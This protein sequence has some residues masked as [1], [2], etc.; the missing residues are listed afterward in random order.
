MLR[1]LLCPCCAARGR[2]PPNPRRDVFW[3]LRSCFFVTAAVHV[4]QPLRDLQLIALGKQRMGTMIIVSTIA[5]ALINPIVGD[6]FQPQSKSGGKPGRCRST[7]ES[8]KLFYR[9][10][11]GNG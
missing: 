9:G 1:E 6:L 10:N 8:L 7:Y 2:R 5:S 4:M 3:L 11:S